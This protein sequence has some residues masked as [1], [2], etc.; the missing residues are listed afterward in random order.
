MEELPQSADRG[1]RTCQ[2]L[3]TPATGL[4]EGRR[5]WRQETGE[6]AKKKKKELVRGQ[7]ASDRQGREPQA[8][9]RPGK[10]RSRR[11]RRGWWALTI[12]RQLCF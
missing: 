7:L 2:R 6:M 8:W 9:E 11:S 10:R 5:G 4:W 1:L 12:D 3:V